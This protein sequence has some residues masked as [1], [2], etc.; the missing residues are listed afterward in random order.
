MPICLIIGDVNFDDLVKIIDTFCHCK[1]RFFILCNVEVMCGEIL[2]DYINYVVLIL[3]LTC[4]FY[5]FYFL[6]LSFISLN[7]VN[8]VISQVVYVNTN[9]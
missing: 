8:T 2:W 5:F 4:F 1:G 6:F 9:F 3:L 7:T